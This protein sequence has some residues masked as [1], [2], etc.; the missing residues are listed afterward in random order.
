MKKKKKK[1]TGRLTSREKVTKM[2]HKVQVPSHQS[3][4][5]LVHAG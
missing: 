2:Q 4:L 3:R 5:D 1:K